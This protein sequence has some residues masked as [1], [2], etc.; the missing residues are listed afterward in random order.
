MWSCHYVLCSEVYL[1]FTSTTFRAKE[2]C[3]FWWLRMS[4]ARWRPLAQVCCV[5][6]AGSAG[7]ADPSIRALAVGLLMCIVEVSSHQDA[8]K[9][10]GGSGQVSR[11]G[12]FWRLL[13]LSATTQQGYYGKHCV[14]KY[15]AHI[16]KAGHSSRF[17][18][19]SLLKLIHTKQIKRGILNYLNVSYLLYGLKEIKYSVTSFSFSVHCRTTYSQN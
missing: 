12:C 3:F 10:V 5:Q 17:F 13:R 8:G 19:D 4:R 6:S 2:V 9:S 14:L 15:Q 1:G 11:E 18:A 7:S 16:N